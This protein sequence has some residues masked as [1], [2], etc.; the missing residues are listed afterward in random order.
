MALQNKTGE[1]LKITRVRPDSKGN[2]TADFDIFQNKSHRETGDI[3]FLKLK[4]GSINGG[5][6]QKELDKTADPK[7]S[8]T[9]NL[10]TAG[11]NAIKADDIEYS[12]WV[13][14]LEAD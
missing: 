12:S 9:N 1:Y 6:L 2:P 7:K 14:V 10:I 8:I 3:G 5:L 4:T 11:Y 13:D